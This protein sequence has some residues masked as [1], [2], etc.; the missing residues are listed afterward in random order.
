MNKRDFVTVA[1][2][3]AAGTQIGAAEAKTSKSAAE[4]KLSLE[5]KIDRLTAMMQRS[6]DLNEV[7]NVVSKMAY[8]YE[9]GMYEERL[10]YIARKTPGVTIEIG[11]RGVFE[12]LEGARRVLVDVEKS[13]E[14]SHAEGMRKAYPN[15]KFESDH[16][17]MFE[18]ELIGTPVIEVAGDGKTARG[19][20][21][22]LMI[23]GK[24]HAED[25]K[26]QA[27]W[28]WWKT[29][30]DF[31]KED[32]EWRIWHMLKNPYF[33]TPYTQDWVEHSLTLPPVP[34]PGTQKGIPGHGS[35]DR[36]T[37]KYYDSYRITRE[38]RL[39]PNPPEPYE[40]YDPKNSFA[41]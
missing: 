19:E 9:A 35:P 18:S 21:L 5:D 30:I 23:S 6:Q 12:G 34:P 14:K 15:L 8:L 36:P 26:P 11:A 38:P 37:T 7:Q 29:S 31:V 10:K 20:W 40:S 33:A 28:I 24:T 1:A 32:G 16:A 22:S 17:G 2:A 13:F 27:Q 41:S 3:L 25:P 4:G 39:Q